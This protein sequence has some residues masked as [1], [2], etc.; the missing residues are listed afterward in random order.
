LRK[1]I[2]PSKTKN[3]LMARSDEPFQ[4]IEKLGDVSSLAN[5]KYN[6]LKEPKSKGVTGQWLRTG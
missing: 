5:S 4:V 2:F 3:K 6:T 1:E